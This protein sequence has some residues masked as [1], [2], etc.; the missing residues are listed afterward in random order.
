[1]RWLVALFL[2]GCT[3]A[4]PAP[5]PRLA[6]LS[7]ALTETLIHLE[8]VDLLVARSEFCTPGE[9]QHLP[10]AGS[11]LTPELERLATLRPSAILIDGSAGSKSAELERLAPVERLPWLTISEVAASTRRL[12]QL[13]DKAA[14]A[15]ALAAELEQTLREAAPKEGP[16]VLA[17]MGGTSPGEGEIWYIRSDSL[18]GA[19]LHAAGARNAIPDP[20]SGPPSISL[21]AL[22]ALD[23]PAILILDGTGDPAKAQTHQQGWARLTTLRAVREGRIAVV[24]DPEIL[25]TGPAILRSVKRVREAVRELA[26]EAP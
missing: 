2:A 24:S 15:N 4:A 20:P 16:E 23:P 19:V 6:S 9:V 7:P 3:S 14:P 22:I 1:M 10:S 21:E 25:A 11:S 5:G 18:H 26:A 8:A 17:V 12:G 13:A